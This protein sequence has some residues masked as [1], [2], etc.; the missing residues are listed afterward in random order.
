MTRKL[1]S[2]KSSILLSWVDFS[3]H[4]LERLGVA[5][6]LGEFLLYI[7]PAIKFFFF[8]FRP[9]RNGAKG[10]MIN[11]AV[12]VCTRAPAPCAAMAATDRGFSLSCD[13]EFA[14]QNPIKIAMAMGQAALCAWEC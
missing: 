5:A 13:V 3:K 7:T 6:F 4:S 12:F 11:L 8:N 14:Y 2:A 1:K 10:R 9:S